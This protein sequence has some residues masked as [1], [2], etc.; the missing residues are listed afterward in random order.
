MSDSDQW[1][2]GEDNSLLLMDD[3]E[4][5]LRRLARAM[6]KRGFAVEAVETVAAGKAIATNWDA[7]RAVMP[8]LNI[9]SRRERGRN[10]P[11]NGSRFHLGTR[12]LCVALISAQLQLYKGFGTQMRECKDKAPKPDK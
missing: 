12:Q 3:D 5:F 11:V 8:N 6:E 10:A 2:I 9:L 4:P 1:E 7:F